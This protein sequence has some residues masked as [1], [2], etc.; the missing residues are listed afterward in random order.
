M[1]AVLLTEPWGRRRGSEHTALPLLA[2]GLPASL[3]LALQASVQLPVQPPG[4]ENKPWQH[5]Y[6]LPPKFQGQMAHPGGLFTPRVT[7]IH[8]A[9]AMPASD[10]QGNEE[11]QPGQLLV[12]GAW[13]PFPLSP[14]NAGVTV[15]QFVTPL[16]AHYGDQ[17]SEEQEPV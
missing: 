14:L 8:V 3:R 13:R 2:S 15:A 12:P 9:V 16:G 10:D 5:G 7:Q 6:N 17:I 11:V 1:R 4:L